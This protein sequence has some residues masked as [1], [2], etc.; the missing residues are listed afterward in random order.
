MAQLK[1]HATPALLH[2]IPDPAITSLQSSAVSLL[3][4]PSTPRSLYTLK[5]GENPP[6]LDK[7][8]CIDLVKRLT[9]GDAALIEKATVGQSVRK[10]WHE[11]CN[12]RLTASNFGNK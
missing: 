11:E 4:L 5:M 6:S 12:G 7:M 8:L 10:R 9:K 1:S 3:P 2:V